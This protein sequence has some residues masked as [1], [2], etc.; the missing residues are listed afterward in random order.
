V[1]APVET[2]PI[3]IVPVPLALIK[4]LAFAPLSITDTTREPPVAVPRMFKP[5]VADAVEEST[6]KIGVVVP[7]GP[8]ARELALVLVI[9]WLA[10]DSVPVNVGLADS[11]MLP[12]PVTALLRVMPP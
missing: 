7:L 11:T 9:V 3:P 1:T 4:R 12:V 10:L 5:T 6:L 2:L 8:T